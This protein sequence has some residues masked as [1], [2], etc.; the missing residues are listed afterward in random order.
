M[1]LSKSVNRDGGRWTIAFAAAALAG[2]VAAILTAL[3]QPAA[4][5]EG[6]AHETGIWAI[7]RGGQLYDKWWAVLEL[8][9][10][11]ETHPAYPAAGKKKGSTT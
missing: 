4:A 11:A 2:L 1:N 5:Q 7:A 10:P 8:E 6:H 9:P 3:P